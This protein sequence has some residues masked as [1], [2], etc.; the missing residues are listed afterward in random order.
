[1]Q[2]LISILDPLLVGMFAVGA[3]GSALVI[4]ISFVEDIHE[5]FSKGE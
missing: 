3:L 2:L 5:L 4:V 1:M